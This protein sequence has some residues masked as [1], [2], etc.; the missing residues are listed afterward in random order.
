MYALLQS[1]DPR[2]AETVY[3]FPRLFGSAVAA[4][5]SFI[6]A[7]A[8]SSSAGFY[9]QLPGFSP[10]AAWAVLL[11]PVLLGVGNTPVQES[12][13]GCCGLEKGQSHPPTNDHFW[14][15]AKRVML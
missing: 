15:S 9:S 3:Q 12:Q 13:E 5:A 6:T 8:L 7:L 14:G 1:K 10:G 4:N 11:S 2:R